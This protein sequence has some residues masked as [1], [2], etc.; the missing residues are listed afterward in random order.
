MMKELCR[1]FPESQLDGCCH[2]FSNLSTQDGFLVPIPCGSGVQRQGVPRGNCF[3][4]KS[5][6]VWRSALLYII[7][8]NFAHVA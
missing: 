2:I 4:K 1:N 7:L 5:L 3:E 8:N 6:L